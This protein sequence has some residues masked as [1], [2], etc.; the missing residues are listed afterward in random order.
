MWD[1]IKHKNLRNE[2]LSRHLVEKKPKEFGFTA[3]CQDSSK[4]SIAGIIGMPNTLG[5]QGSSPI[6]S[7]RILRVQLRVL[8]TLE[9]GRT[10]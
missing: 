3:I 5:K 6:P 10:T 7:E 1:F 4:V 8:R 9:K 2:K